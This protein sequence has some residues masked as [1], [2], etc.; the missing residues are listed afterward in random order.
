MFL[1]AFKLAIDFTWLIPTWF[2]IILAT[3]V[4]S[5]WE[6]LKELGLIEL[7]QKYIDLAH[8]SLEK[9]MAM[10]PKHQAKWLWMSLSISS[11]ICLNYLYL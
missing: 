1:V 8:K 5:A 11:F 2:L 10:I 7:A 6:F 9:V 4:F 3:E